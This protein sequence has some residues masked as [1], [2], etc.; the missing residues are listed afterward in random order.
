MKSREE[1]FKLTFKKWLFLNRDKLIKLNG[2][3]GF[4][5]WCDKD[6]ICLDFGKRGGVTKIKCEEIK[7]L[8]VIF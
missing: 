3:I 6:F 8:E 1:G 2:R 4:Y 5:I 7:Q